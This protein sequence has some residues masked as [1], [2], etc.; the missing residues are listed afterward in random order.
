M[1]QAKSVQQKWLK[2]YLLLD[3]HTML[4]RDYTYTS[5]YDLMVLTYV[6]FNF[7]RILL[8]FT[9]DKPLIKILGLH[10]ANYPRPVEFWLM[11]VF[12]AY[13]Y[14]L[15]LIVTIIWLKVRKP[16][17]VLR[18][19]SLVSLTYSQN[20]LNLTQRGRICTF[21]KHA[22]KLVNLALAPYYVFEINGMLKTHGYQWSAIGLFWSLVNCHIAFDVYMKSLNFLVQFLIISD[23]LDHRLTRI[24][25]ELRCS[26]LIETSVDSYQSIRQFGRIIRKF[27]RIRPILNA[28]FTCHFPFIPLSVLC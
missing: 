19:A 21:Y 3:T 20:H 25:S 26:L 17:F 16:L 10:F 4:I 13:L 28:L 5:G 22:Q 11:L 9:A 7:I 2:S 1:D 23:T 14:P 12:F 6:V 27:Y 18:F 8:T 15:M 24:K